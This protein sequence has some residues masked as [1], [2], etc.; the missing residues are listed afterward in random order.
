MSFI[1]SPGVIFPPLTAGG[2]AYGTGS[3]AKVNTA[4]I[5]GQYLISGGAGVPTFT[6]LGTFTTV[7]CTTLNVT[8]ISTFG[9]GTAALPGLTTTGDTNT[10]IYFPAADTLGFT[11]GGTERMRISS[12][13]LSTF[14]GTTKVT[15]GAAVGNATPGAGGLAFPVTAV[16]VAD[17]NTLDD[18]EEGNWT[19]VVTF[20]GG[21]GDLTTAEAL[22][23]Y[24][25]IGRLVQ[26]SFNVEFTETTALTNLTITG[27][28]FTSGGVSRSAAGC[29]IDNM[30]LVSGAPLILLGLTS[31]TITVNQTRTGAETSITNLNTGASSR[32]RGIL[33][34]S[35]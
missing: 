16:A 3:Q 14:T 20:T 12:A 34:Y 2:V 30:T 26:I 27:V 24:T 1:T 17:A 33:T 31:T 15:T 10:G 35:I 7:N 11:T 18:Y 4:G 32:V 21:N 19:P 5:L 6:D 13:G 28:P 8:G 9:A 25:K 23:V 29:F 22:G